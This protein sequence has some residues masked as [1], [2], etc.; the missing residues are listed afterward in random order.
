M[1]FNDFLVREGREG[2]S[3]LEYVISRREDL[4]I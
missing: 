3:K 2:I 1:N 4:S